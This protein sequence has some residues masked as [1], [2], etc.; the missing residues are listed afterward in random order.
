ML[1]Q[2]SD[3]SVETSGDD[4]STRAKCR[5]YCFWSAFCQGHNDVKISDIQRYDIKL[6]TASSLLRELSRHLLCVL[7]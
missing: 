1:A 2:V 7:K 3:A 6:R 5:K 4:G